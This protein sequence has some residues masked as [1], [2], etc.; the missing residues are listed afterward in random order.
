MLLDV[1]SQSRGGRSISPE[2]S[3]SVILFREFWEFTANPNLAFYTVSTVRFFEV[4][5]SSRILKNSVK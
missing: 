5:H 1:N 3:I 4:K 2:V